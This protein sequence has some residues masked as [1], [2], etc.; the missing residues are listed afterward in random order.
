MPCEATSL[1]SHK[2]CASN[3]RFE[4]GF[5]LSSPQPELLTGTLRS[6]LDPFEEYD[7]AM[8][9]GALKSAGLDSLQSDME[10]DEAKITLDS[11]IASGGGNLSVGQRQIMALARALVR[12]SKVLILD[13]GV[14]RYFAQDIPLMCHYL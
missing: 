7:D 3:S 8:L 12:R 1:S 2:W 4:F 11:T 6:N 14:S 9:N 10:S 5:L 13:E